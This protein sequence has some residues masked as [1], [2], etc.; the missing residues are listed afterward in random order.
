MSEVSKFLQ[1]R[2]FDLSLDMLCIAHFSGHFLKLSAA[3]ERTLG[4]TR[5]ELQSKRMFEFVHPDDR[6][7]TLEQNRIVRSGGRALG[8]EN[9]YMCKDGSY[10]W[11]RWNAI[12]DMDHQLIYS[13]ARDITES[14]RAEEER[15]RLLRELQ[16][17]L[18]E[19]KELRE[20]L[21]MCMYCKSIRSDQ[22]YWQSV[23][24]YIANHTNAQLSHGICPNCYNNTFKVELEGQKKP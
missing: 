5:G 1:D 16:S 9:R 14:K 19:V 20:I 3:W 12:A 8:F 7:R 15:E 24:V 6:E 2:F 23:E 10:R 22:N 21:P 17:A 18:G 11:F 4:F 13:L